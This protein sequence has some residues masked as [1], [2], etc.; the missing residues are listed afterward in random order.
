M[1]ETTSLPTLAPDEAALT[2]CTAAAAQDSA[3]AIQATEI[4]TLLLMAR[5]CTSQQLTIA[6]CA[7][8]AEK[9]DS[10]EAETAQETDE[11]EADI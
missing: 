2:L 11:I 10:V 5:F 9:T 8:V 1:E 3:V 6:Y 7:E 4:G